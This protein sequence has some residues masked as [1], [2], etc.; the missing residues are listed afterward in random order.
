MLATVAYE[1]NIYLSSDSGATWSPV[2]SLGDKYWRSVA[3]SSNGDRLAAVF[4]SGSYLAGDGLLEGE[5]SFLVSS[6]TKKRYFDEYDYE[7]QKL[8]IGG[9]V[10]LIFIL[11]KN[12]QLLVICLFSKLKMKTFYFLM[13]TIIYWVIWKY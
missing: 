4:N 2:E 11:K 3:M 8:I 13:S 5:Y 10:I 9:G 7:D 6:M 1:D 12:S